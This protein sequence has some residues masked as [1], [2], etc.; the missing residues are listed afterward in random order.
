MYRYVC[1]YRCID[2]YTYRRIDGWRHGCLHRLVWMGGWM[3][4]WMGVGG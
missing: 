1:R 3:S 4:G 2:G